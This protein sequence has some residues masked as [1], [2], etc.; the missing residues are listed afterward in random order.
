MFASTC[1]LASTVKA[2]AAKW[3][4]RG[5][6]ILNRKSSGSSS[7][8]PAG[9]TVHRCTSAPSVSK[10]GKLFLAATDAVNSPQE[11]DVQ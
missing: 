10:S 8:C 11:S 6:S 3:I 4:R 1:L 2:E 5:G 9:W 7:P